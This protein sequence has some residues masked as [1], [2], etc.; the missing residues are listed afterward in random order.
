MSILIALLL[1]VGQPT[2]YTVFAT[3]S[4]VDT[5]NWTAYCTDQ[6]GHVYTFEVEDEW[7]EGD[8]VRMTVCNNGTTFTNDDYVTA[9]YY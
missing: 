2:Y 8:S 4:R 6:S 5:N 3:V 7:N 9:V 1:A